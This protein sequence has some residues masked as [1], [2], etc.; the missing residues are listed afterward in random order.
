MADK[1][2]A[3][4]A[5]KGTTLSP[6]FEPPD[7]EPQDHFPYQ[8]FWHL[9]RGDEPVKYSDITAY[10]DR[11]DCDDADELVEIVFALDNVLQDHREK[12]RKAQQAKDKAR[13]KKH[14]GRR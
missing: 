8:A 7:L 12:Q 1:I 5:E 10:A 2:R 14:G 13:S 4:S 3:A 11:H 9:K 6:D